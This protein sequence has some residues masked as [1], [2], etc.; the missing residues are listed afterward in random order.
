MRQATPS[1]SM[2]EES[3]SDEAT[4]VLLRSPLGSAQSAEEPDPVPPP[5]PTKAAAIA[6]PNVANQAANRVVMGNGSPAEPV[7]KRMLANPHTALT[8]Q[9]EGPILA[10]S[11]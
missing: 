5:Q 3:M 7:P 8:V 1:W 4:R 11:D 10:Y 6:T 9:L 2:L